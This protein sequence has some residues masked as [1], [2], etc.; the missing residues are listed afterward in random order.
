MAGSW[1]RSRRQWRLDARGHLGATRDGLA[2]SLTGGANKPAQTAR[3]GH[4]LD[5]PAFPA[6]V[7]AGKVL[8][9]CLPCEPGGMKRSSYRPTF[10]I[11]RV[12]GPGRFPCFLLACVPLL[13]GAHRFQFA[14][15]GTPGRPKAVRSISIWFFTGLGIVFSFAPASRDL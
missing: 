8:R 12:A 10:L 3:G 6:P 13:A 9:S 7:F 1:R 11:S 14:G 15:N 4:R 2:G 5:V